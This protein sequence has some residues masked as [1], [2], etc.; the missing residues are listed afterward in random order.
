MTIVKSIIE[1]IV[2]SGQES[3][4]RVL[5]GQTF[6]HN[7]NGDLHRVDG[8]AVIRWTGTKHWCQNN[9][10]HRENGPAIE[11]SDGSYSWYLRGKRH[12]V[13]GPATKLRSGAQEWW[14]NDR[15]FTEDEFNLYVDQLTG[16]VLI[17]PGKKLTHDPK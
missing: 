4:K 8:P 12:R 3:T 13:D 2:E 15:Q 14:V 7:K 5:N 17:P 6:W 10:L 9:Q 16:E 11:F 1:A